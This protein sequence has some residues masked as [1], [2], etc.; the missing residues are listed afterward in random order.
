LK[1][2]QTK[3]TIPVSDF[4]KKRTRDCIS[5]RL[6]KLNPPLFSLSTGK[7]GKKKLQLGLTAEGGFFYS[8]PA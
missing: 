3:G 5:V 6:E 2:S 1:K 8:T 4:L 7:G